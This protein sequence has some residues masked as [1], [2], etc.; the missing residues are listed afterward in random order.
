MS[1]QKDD[2]AGTFIIGVLLLAA[3]VALGGRFVNV[4]WTDATRP[5]RLQ[6]CATPLRNSPESYNGVSLS[7][8]G[9]LPPLY[10]DYG[11]QVTPRPR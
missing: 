9:R 2:S 7:C 3:L 10:D 1:D 6:V 5:A 8:D 4:T 11:R